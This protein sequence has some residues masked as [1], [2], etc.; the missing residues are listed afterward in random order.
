MRPDQRP[1]LVPVGFLWDNNEEIL[2]I[3]KPENQKIRNIRQNKN[4][5]LALETLGV[6]G[7]VVLLD[8]TAEILSTPSS[9]V[10][11][12]AYIT[13][14]GQTM[15]EMGWKLEDMMQEYSQ[16]IRIKLARVVH[17]GES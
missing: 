8:G 6:G 13:K 7:D 10:V 2:I 4:V 5:A 16:V 9:E 14:Y 17:W 3:S 1:H 12:P 15:Q 11:S